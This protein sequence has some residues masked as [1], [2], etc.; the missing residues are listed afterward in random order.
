MNALS[1]SDHTQFVPTSNVPTTS[2]VQCLPNVHYVTADKLGVVK[3]RQDSIPPEDTTHPGK[4]TPLPA[5]PSQQ[6]NTS[7]AGT[8][9]IVLKQCCIT[10]LSFVDTT[11]TYVQCVVIIN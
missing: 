3:L 11:F 8:K 4:T 6:P 1:D 7:V 2:T 10:T 9:R 5:L